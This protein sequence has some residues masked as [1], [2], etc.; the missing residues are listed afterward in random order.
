MKLP[1][2]GWITLRW[3]PITPRPAATATGLCATTQIRPG[4][5]S[6]SI[7]NDIDGLIARYPASWRARVIRCAASFMISPLRWNS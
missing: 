7:G 3:M 5:R 2:F 4:N 6:I 1:N